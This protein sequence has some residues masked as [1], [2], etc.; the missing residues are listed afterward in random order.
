MASKE[1]F[2]FS[3]EIE[4]NDVEA[5]QQFNEQWESRS[6]VMDGPEVSPPDERELASRASVRLIAQAFTSQ[7]K[8]T[9]LNLRSLQVLD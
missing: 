6:G 1:V 4:L 3:L 2:T 9:G 5:A 8:E 7:H